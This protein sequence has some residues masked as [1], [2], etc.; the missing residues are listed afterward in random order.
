MEDY[1]LWRRTYTVELFPVANLPVSR[2]RE[3]QYLLDMGIEQLHT[4]I[5][6]LKLEKTLKDMLEQATKNM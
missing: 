6:L 1:S 4:L 3:R 5:K 2:K